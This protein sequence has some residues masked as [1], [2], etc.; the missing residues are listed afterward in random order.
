MNGDLDRILGLSSP[1]GRLPPG[2][3]GVVKAVGLTKWYG[4][5]LG[6]ND[7]HLGIESGT[8]GLLGPNG[9]GKSTFLK[10]MTGQIRP[11]KGDVQI[12]GTSVW[13]NPKV[14]GR[15]GYSPEQDAF[16]RWMTGFEFVSTLLRVGGY[17]KVDA[18]DMAEDSLR[19]LGMTGAMDRKIAGYSKGMRQ[20]VKVAQAIAH[21]PDLLVLDEPLS[22]TDPV[23]RTR[24]LKVIRRLENEGKDVIL[25]SHVLHDV[26]RTTRNIVLINRGKVIAEGDVHDIRGLIDQYPHMVG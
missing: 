26:E 17:S 19:V 6:V 25:S 8:T 9:A 16:Y 20:R 14:M 21:Y 24:I 22:G 23:G 7:V 15:V 1:D 10:L 3:G 4:L 5:V 18:E 11:S 2:S 13:N 12:F